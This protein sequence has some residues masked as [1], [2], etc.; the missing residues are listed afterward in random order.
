MLFRSNIR[1]G[2]AHNPDLRVAIP[3]LAVKGKGDINL[4]VLS[5][6]Y[7]LGVLIQGD[8]QPMADPACQVNQ[9]YKNIEWPVRCR[10]PLE[11][12]AKACRIDED[13]LGKIATG[14][15]SEKLN[16][17]L[18]EKLGDKISPKLDR[19]APELKDTLKGLFKR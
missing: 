1:N 4:R 12:G 16:E 14:M 10:G 11:L 9:R 3:G 2:I 13:G 8:T 5:L 19:L 6:D 18:Q 15:V 7:Y 17:K